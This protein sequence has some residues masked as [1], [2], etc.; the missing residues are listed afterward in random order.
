MQEQ[1]YLGRLFFPRVASL[2]NNLPIPSRKRESLL[3]FKKDLRLYYFDSIDLMLLLFNS[4][5]IIFITH[6]ILLLL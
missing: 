1:N 3:M 4:V 6:N 5:S 2:W